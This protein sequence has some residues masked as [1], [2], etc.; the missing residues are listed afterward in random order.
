MDSNGDN[1]AGAR[2]AYDR[3][4]W[5]RLHTALDSD[6]VALL[7]E[8]IERI[9]SQPRPE[10]VHE[11]DGHHVRAVHGCHRYDD[12]CSRL[13]RLPRLVDLAEA[14]V[15]EPVYV[16]Q[17]K[18]NLK[19][20]HHGAAWPWHQ[21]YA[22]W[23]EEDGMPAPKAVNLALLL[24]AADLGNGPLLVIPGSQ[25]LG[26]LDMP[27]GGARAPHGDWRNHVS[28]DLTYTVS[29]EVAGRLAARSGT[30][31]LLGPAGTIYAF[32]PSIVHASSD[33]HSPD[34]RSLLLITYNAVS[35]AP[36]RPTRPAFLVDTDVA[37]VTRLTVDRLLPASAFN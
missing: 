29:A 18:V 21:D 16:Y 2:A 4:G 25:C 1:L 27:A 10:V 6:E 28:A 35:N 23:R 7:C 26:L 33:N 34:R 3:D 17:F 36:A 8:R 12:V 5:Y 22:F 13:T 11:R 9:I 37:A 32:H 31:P 30:R 20:P 14:L 19:Q 24:D 15:G